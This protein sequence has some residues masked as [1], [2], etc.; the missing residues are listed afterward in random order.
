MKRTTRMRVGLEKRL[1]PILISL[2]LL[3]AISPRALAAGHGK[4]IG[5]PGKPEP[6]Q[7]SE[8]KEKKTEAPGKPTPSP[9]E[10]SGKQYT[11]ISVDKIAQAIESVTDSEQQSEL[12]KLLDAY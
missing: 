3:F 7:T 2:V 4:P 12:T 5:K 8:P 11:G 1:V 10:P 6:T 9:E